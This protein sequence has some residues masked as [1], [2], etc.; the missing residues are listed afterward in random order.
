MYC[1]IQ[2]VTICASNH[3]V[4]Y[5]FDYHQAMCV[6][7]CCSHSKIPPDICPIFTLEFFL[8]IIP[9]SISLSFSDYFWWKYWLPIH[10]PPLLF[11]LHDFFFLSSAINCWHP[12]PIL[13]QLHHVTLLQLLWWPS[14]FSR[15]VANSLSSDPLCNTIRSSI[16]CRHPSLILFIFL[17]AVFCIFIHFN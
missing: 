8:S 3:A 16:P 1:H 14:S 10:F 9:L 11:H 2:Y 5:I 6:R 4:T 7:V 15:N 13:S 12:P 17:S